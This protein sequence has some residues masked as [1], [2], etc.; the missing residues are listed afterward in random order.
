VPRARDNRRRAIPPD[1]V[2]PPRLSTGQVSH[3]LGV[4]LMTVRNWRYAGL[5]VPVELFRSGDRDFAIYDGEEIR[6]FSN[7]TFHPRPGARIVKPVPTRSPIIHQI[8]DGRSSRER[9]NL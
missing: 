1:E 4:S 5:I 9:V 3:L 6:R 2:I 8:E 7:A